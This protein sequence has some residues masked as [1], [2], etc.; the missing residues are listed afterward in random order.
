M[1][2]PHELLTDVGLDVLL[3]FTAEFIFRYILAQARARAHN[4]WL[5]LVQYCFLAILCVVLHALHH[6]PLVLVYLS[7]LSVFWRI[8]TACSRKRTAHSNT[9]R[10]L[11]HMHEPN[12]NSQSPTMTDS[13]QI[14]W[15]TGEQASF[16]THAHPNPTESA[17][18]YPYP[19]RPLPVG[20]KR[21]M[22]D[23]VFLQRSPLPSHSLSSGCASSQGYTPLPG[24]TP[25]Q[26]PKVKTRN[27]P[28]L[29][30]EQP[31][32]YLLSSPSFLHHLKWPDIGLSKLSSDNYPPGIINSGNTCFLNSSIQCLSWTG[33]FLGVFEK[34]LC[35]DSEVVHALV[36]IMKQCRDRKLDAIDPAPLLVAIAPLAPH[37]VSVDGGQAQQDAAEFLLWVLDTV[38]SQYKVVQQPLHD[39]QARVEKL[40]NEKQALMA[41]MEKANSTIISSYSDVLSQLSQVNRQLLK[42]TDSSP[43]YDLCCG[44]LVEARECQKCRMVSVNLESYTVLPLPVLSDTGSGVVYSLADCFSCFSEVE[45]LTRSSNMLHCTCTLQQPAAAL[46]SA[47]VQTDAG[48]TPG[49][50]LTLLSYLP[51]K[52]IIQLTRFSY[53][54]IHNSTLKNQSSVEFPVAGLDLAHFQME[55]KLQM[56]CI[57][58]SKQLYDLSAFCVHTGARSTSFGHYIAYCKAGTSGLWYCFNDKSVWAID[59][60]HKEIASTF[61][62]KNAYIL[63]YSMRE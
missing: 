4:S 10:P 11:K 47:D 19:W 49:K 31:R 15:N 5:C 9:S 13:N 34:A 36:T 24:Y 39:A 48:L 56:P 6:T 30:S 3:F 29:I 58:T 32:G 33:G 23:H 53:D 38:H 18:Q 46:M 51:Q 61:V 2:F 54:T 50:R 28:S 59:D 45:E 16:Q 27:T 62:L 41:K 7:V 42:V 44:Q 20:R 35:D 60:I 14:L 8:L 37:L 25:S 26:T 12:R 22:S 52:L 17:H 1:Y 63:F 21:S 57:E 40:L 55:T 43:V